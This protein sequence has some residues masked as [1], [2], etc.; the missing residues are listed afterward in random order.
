[1]D[2]AETIG[3]LVESVQAQTCQPRVD[4][5]AHSMGTISSRY[6]IKNLG[7]LDEVNTYVTLGGLV[8]VEEVFLEVLR[9]L[10]YPCW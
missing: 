3:Q 4:I 2:N 1:M 8:E 5:V 10:Q 6:Y 9:V 7:G